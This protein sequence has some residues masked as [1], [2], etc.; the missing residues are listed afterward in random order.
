[1]INNVKVY[2]LENAVRVAKFP[3]AIDTNK[4]TEE[5]I[6]VT[7]SLAKTE[8]GSAHNNFLCGIIVQFDLTATLKF[9]PE[10][11]RYH[12][13]DIISS[14]STMHRI[15]RFNLDEAYYKYTDKRII[16]IMKE[17]VAGYNAIEDKTSDKAKE[18]YLEVLYNNPAG[19]LLTAGITTNYLQLKT[20]YKQRHNHRLEEWRVF[21]KWIESLPHSEWMTN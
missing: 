20:M 13:A 5:I 7:N 19:F 14:Q 18:K 12:F 6:P 17:K 15:T 4:C 10:F 3:M 9:W 16:D 1:M 11:Q 21:C 2:G 8:P